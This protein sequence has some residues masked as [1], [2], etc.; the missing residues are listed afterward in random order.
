MMLQLSGH[1]EVLY[2]GEGACA[3]IAMT[4]GRGNAGVAEIAGEPTSTRNI[5]I[6]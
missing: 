4:R 1:G 2:E 6:S 5:T 3:R